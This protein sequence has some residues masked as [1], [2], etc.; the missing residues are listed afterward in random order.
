MAPD[1]CSAVEQ[2]D[3]PRR[4]R[5]RAAPLPPVRIALHDC[6]YELLR[7]VAARLGWQVVERE[8]EDGGSK[9]FE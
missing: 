7:L 9:Y 2:A 3:T 1:E 4:A 5:P 8:P 6:K